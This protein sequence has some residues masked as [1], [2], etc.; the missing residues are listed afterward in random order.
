MVLGAAA[1]LVGTFLL[2][3]KRALMG[4]VL[5]H[6][7]LPGVAVAFLVFASIDGGKSL[8]VLLLGAGLAAVLA[9]VVMLFLRRSTGLGEDA[10]MAITLGTSFGLGVVLLGVALDSPKGNQA[11]LE[12]FIYGKTASM[13]RSD[14][15]LITVGA[16]V[17]LAAIV[18]LFKELKLLCFDEAFA[19]SVGALRLAFLMRFFFWQSS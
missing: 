17:V 16:C 15:M 12:S 5:S 18:L 2:L 6:A 4:D 11:G 8:P 1:G 19:G 9:V 7:T 13:T 10:V 3:R 14:L